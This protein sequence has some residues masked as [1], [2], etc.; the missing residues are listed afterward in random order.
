MSACN[1]K[2]YVPVNN[3][4]GVWIFC[5]KEAEQN[6]EEMQSFCNLNMKQLLGRSEVDNTRRPGPKGQRV[7]G[8]LKRL[9][10]D[11]F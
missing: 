10:W 11:D 4:A 7:K 2:T 6:E 3:I 9:K 5:G 1:D 8:H